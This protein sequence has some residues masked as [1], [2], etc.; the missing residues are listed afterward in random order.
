MSKRRNPGI[1]QRRRTPEMP[2]HD[3]VL[4]ILR[5]GDGRLVMQR[6][7]LNAPVSPGLLGLFGGGIEAGEE[8]LSA[9]QREL[10]E[11]TSLHQLK[12]S[13]LG[14]IDLV[15][16]HRSP[17]TRTRIHIFTA[18]LPAA[19]FVVYEGNG[20]E[21]FPLADLL[22]RDDLGPTARSVLTADPRLADSR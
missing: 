22:T 15:E 11:E 5:L 7:D 14:E 18:T 6:R 20:V 13:P 10:S 4:A 19:D 3:A 8:P 17:P 12:F 16:S 2:V 9:I 1:P 21:V